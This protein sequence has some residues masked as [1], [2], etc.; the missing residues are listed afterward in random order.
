MLLFLAAIYTV[1]DA[2]FPIHLPIVDE[3][4]LETQIS[5]VK[6]YILRNRSTFA[7]SRHCLTKTHRMEVNLQSKLYLSLKTSN[8]S[9]FPSKN[10]PLGNKNTKNFSF[11]FIS[12][13]AKNFIFNIVVFFNIVFLPSFSIIFVLIIRQKYP[14][15]MNLYCNYNY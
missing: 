11:E 9:H 12:K 4:R 5:F 10:H 15:E 8:V 1:P 13:H 7:C 2:R 14:F 3:M 6:A